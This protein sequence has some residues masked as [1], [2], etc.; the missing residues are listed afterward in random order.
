MRKNYIT[1]EQALQIFGD[2]MGIP[3]QEKIGAIVV[4]S[5]FVNKVPVQFARTYNLV[6][7]KRENGTMTVATNAPFD[8]HPMDDLA[9]LMGCEVEPVLVPRAEIANV[10]N[11][12]YKQKSDV[13]D[14]ALGGLA[15]E[16]IA[17]IT[18]IIEESDD[19]LDVANKAPI[20]KLVN[21]ILFQALKMRASDIHIQPFED[22]LQIRYR[23]DGILYDMEAPPK[24]V[25]EAIIS[26]VKVMGKM[27][28]AERRLPQ[29]GRA[30]IRIGDTEVDVRIS[31]VPTNYGE[32]IVMRLLD[33]GSRLLTLEQL[34]LGERN[35]EVLEKY[36]HFPNGIIFVTGPTGSGKTTTLYAVL[37]QINSAEKN[38]LTLEDPIEYNLPGI[39][40]IQ[41][42]S[43]KGL[44]FATG[45]RS[46]LRQDPDV[47]MVGEVRDVE[48]ARI[49]IQSAL[50]GHL[51]FS[52]LHTNDAAGAV[53]RMLDIGLE[54][55]LVSS[56]LILVVAQRL[57]RII[58]ENCKEANKPTETDLKKMRE[59]NLSLDMLPGGKLFKGRGCDTCFNTGFMERTAIYEM[60]P[61][62]DVVRAQIM[63]RVG[64]TII[65]KKAVE[66]G[67]RTLR[68]DGVDRVI[69]GKTTVDEVLKVTQMD[70]F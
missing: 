59:V 20:I 41:V 13:V 19:L 27:D 22:R 66:R 70:V 15:D 6:A 5:E 26:R 40:Q 29:D 8:I 63:D 2:A 14:E 53:T 10:I 11:R 48:T 47:M 54:P 51:V 12:A 31:S 17:G 25:Q 61:I 18:K 58:C 38:V 62:D 36:I 60:L 34:G 28:I 67:Y 39:S 9:T 68:I 3:Y 4:P 1:E 16:D 69:K 42:S 52:T 50:T 23:I 49:A 30:T 32:R 37:T 55:Y 35:L 21:M 44:T 45:L 57:V 7:L 33:K 65:K 24:K 43:K 64:S 56:S 46:L